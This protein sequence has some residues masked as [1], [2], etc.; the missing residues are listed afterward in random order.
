MFG[1]CAKSDVKTRHVYCIKCTHEKCNVSPVEYAHN[2]FTQNA[3]N[4]VQQTSNA[5]QECFQT[6]GFGAKTDA[7]MGHVQ[8]FKCSHETCNLGSVEY[9]HNFFAKN[10]S[11]LLKQGPN[12]EW[13]CLQTF[14]LGANTD[15]KTG[16]VQ[17]IKWTHKKLNLG[18]VEFAHNIF[19]KNVSN[20]VRQD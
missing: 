15:A 16:Q 13:E 3:S 11:N 10:T 8:C 19:S 14:G 17:C 1:F 2:V 5:D 7:K 4:L 9:V 6:F 12:K 18:P 20:L